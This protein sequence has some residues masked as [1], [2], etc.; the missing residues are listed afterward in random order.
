MSC[1]SIA[2]S[3]HALTDLAEDPA[4]TEGRSDGHGVQQGRA[5]VRHRK[6]QDERSKWSAQSSKPAKTMDDH[7][8]CYI[9]SGKI[10]CIVIYCPRNVDIHSYILIFLSKMHRNELL[11]IHFL[12]IPISSILDT[13]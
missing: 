10:H 7:F 3:S 5:E 11:L 1:S 6:V 9:T 4:L 8:F 13:T 12:F 2:A